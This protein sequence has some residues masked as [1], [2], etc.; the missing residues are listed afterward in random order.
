MLT[1][2]SDFSTDRL[3]TIFWVILD[4]C[5]FEDTY[6]GVLHFAIADIASQP[7]NRQSVAL[8]KCRIFTIGNVHFHEEACH[9]ANYL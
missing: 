8:Y 4:W 5:P 6:L 2:W 3:L 1:Y 9:Y 7:F